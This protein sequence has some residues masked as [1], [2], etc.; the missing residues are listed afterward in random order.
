MICDIMGLSLSHYLRQALHLKRVYTQ[1]NPAYAERGI[2][3][4]V[5]NFRK[6]S[7]K[8]VDFII[9]VV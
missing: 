7:K 1:T 9:V 6:K 8:V 2:L 3:L 4:L 5:E